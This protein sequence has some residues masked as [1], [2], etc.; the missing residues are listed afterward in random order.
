MEERKKIN[1]QLQ[2]LKPIFEMLEVLDRTIGRTENNDALTFALAGADIGNYAVSLAGLTAGVDYVVN[3]NDYVVNAGVAKILPKTI[4]AVGSVDKV[5]D[6]A[7]ANNSFKVEEGIID[8]DAVNVECEYDSEMVGARNATLTIDNTNY[9]LSTT[10]FVGNITPKAIALDWIAETAYEYNAKDQTVS[11]SVSGM[12]VGYEESL[13][14]T[15]DVEKSFIGN[16]K[17]SFKNAGD[18][19]VTIALKANTNYTLEG[20]ETTKEWS[21]SK[22]TLVVTW[23]EENEFTYNASEFEYAPVVSGIIDGDSVE[24]S[25]TGTKSTNAGTYT[26]SIDA[27]SGESVDNYVLPLN[28][29][30]EW[31]IQKTEISGITLTGLD[32]TYDGQAKEIAVSS[33]VTQY[34]DAISVIYAGGESANSATNAGEYNIIA[35]IEESQ[36][37]LAL[38][39]TATIKI[40]KAEI[41]DVTLSDLVST[42][43]GEV[44]SVSVSALTTSYGDAVAVTY[45][46]SGTT[47]GGVEIEESTNGTKDAG[48]YS[49]VAYPA[50]LHI[51]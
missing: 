16:T 27:I 28:V 38:T 35:T 9:T 13:A 3:D 29:Q 26:A 4:T 2:L 10:T 15:G 43:D 21:I 1:E 41:T 19:S 31:T 7:R 33:L 30:K 20:Q 39:L 25:I 23:D 14:V 45:A 32:A 44:K 22:K 42:Y 34:G 48:E 6:G 47:L 17:F 8:G 18:Y 11:V 5:F 24:I 51:R 50:A 40:A 36:N 49:V 46:I 37:Y 12:V